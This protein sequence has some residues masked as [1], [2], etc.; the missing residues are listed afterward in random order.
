MRRPRLADRETDLFGGTEF[1]VSDVLFKTTN[2][3][4]PKKHRGY[5][6]MCPSGGIAAALP[7][8]LIVKLINKT[9]FYTETQFTKDAG[10]VVLL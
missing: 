7:S 5:P 8:N 9:K 6:D 2:A 4:A 1:I 10:V 3:G